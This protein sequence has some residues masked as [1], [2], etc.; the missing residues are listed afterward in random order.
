[1]W[2]GH[3]L[4]SHQ[5]P[6]IINC[7]ANTNVYLLSFHVEKKITLSKL[8]SKMVSPEFSFAMLQLNFISLIYL[9]ILAQS[10]SSLF[11]LNASEL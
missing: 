10:M 7:I 8:D 4:H 1:M 3:L 5:M 11:L 6:L 9:S 2:H